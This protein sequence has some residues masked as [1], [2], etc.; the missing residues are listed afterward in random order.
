MLVGAITTLDNLFQPRTLTGWHVD[1]IH[2]ARLE[3]RE[4]EKAKQERQA[5]CGALAELK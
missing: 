2:L 3:V 5:L 4:I 1:G